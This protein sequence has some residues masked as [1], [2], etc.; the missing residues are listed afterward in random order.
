MKQKSQL[1]NKPLTRQR[2]K[3]FTLIELLVVILIIAILAAMIV[4]RI[5]G[6]QADAK[7][8]KA[9]SDIA[10]LES[11]L[12]TYRLDVGYYPTTEEGLDALFYQ[13]NGAEGWNGPYSRREISLDPWGNE[14]FYEYLG[15]GEQESYVLMSFGKDGQEGGTGE[16]ED[17]PPIG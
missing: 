17:L 6:R 14:Y 5:V 3:A 4:P 10:A 9:L 16:N 8:A 2:N 1:M 15:D 12:E 7:K 13:P 11:M